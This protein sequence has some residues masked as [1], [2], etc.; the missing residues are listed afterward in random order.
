MINF[1]S[2]RLDNSIQFLN[3]SPIR[4][5]LKFVLLNLGSNFSEDLLSSFKENP[6]CFVFHFATW[7]F[8]ARTWRTK[9]MHGS[10]PILSVRKMTEMA[11][12][13]LHES[14]KLVFGPLVLLAPE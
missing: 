4:I 9:F 13:F 6:D 12:N 7:F 8:F 3:S 14:D 1:P 10:L 2:L 11:T 5:G